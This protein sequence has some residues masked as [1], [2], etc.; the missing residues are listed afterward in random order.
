MTESTTHIEAIPVSKIDEDPMFQVRL[1]WEPA[2]DTG[3][4]G[5]AASLAGLEGLIHPVVVVRL[6][7]P[8]IFGRLYTLIAGHRRLAAARRLGWRTILARVLPPCDLTAPLARLHLLAVAVREN[9]EREDLPPADRRAAL[10]RLEALYAAVYPET[11]AR[12]RPSGTGERSPGPFPRWAT[13]VTKIPERT[14]RRDLR[15][16][17]LTG[18]PPPS[19]SAAS[20]A[21]LPAPPAMEALSAVVPRTI[22]AALQ[23]TTGLQSLATAHPLETPTALPAEQ[24]TTLHQT[25]EALQTALTGVW[26]VVRVQ[27]EHPLVPFVL[28]AQEH[29]AAL[30]GTLWGLRAGAPEVWATLPPAVARQFHTAMSMLLADWHEIA[31]LVQTRLPGAPASDRTLPPPPRPVGRP[32]A[33]A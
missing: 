23:A 27:T 1:Q 28:V 33:V 5:L 25:L 30:R 12:Q 32:V 13:K 21:P 14:I 11:V 20:S 4:E 2:T 16:V 31:P 19:A 6:A 9:T 18:G 8:T 7:Q 10:R 17:L 15:G 24:F 22:E 3:L 29:L 26:P